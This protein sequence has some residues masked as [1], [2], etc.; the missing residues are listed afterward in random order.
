MADTNVIVPLDE[1]INKELID[2]NIESNFADLEPQ[3]RAFALSYV[4]DYDH[5]RAA[6]EAGIKPNRGFSL[7]RDPLVSAFIKF[8]QD[9][10]QISNIITADFIKA[11][12]LALIPKLAGQEDIPIILPDG[13]Q[14]EGKKFY[15][16]E[17]TNVLKELAKST[18]FYEDGSGQGGGVNI[19]ID[20][21]ALTGDQTSVAMIK[22]STI[23]QVKVLNNNE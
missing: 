18:K 23:E 22:G 1:N 11:Q 14:I 3:K 15:P 21:G 6:M 10:L 2:R 13:E 4:I 12:Y 5:R 17:L 16:G 8:L 19:T 9:E 7:L 20:V